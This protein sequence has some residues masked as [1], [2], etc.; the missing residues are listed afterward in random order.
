MLQSRIKNALIL[1]GNATA[2]L[3][4]ITVSALGETACPR[5][6]NLIKAMQLPYLSL[7]DEDPWHVC[8]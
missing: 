1:V 2:F 5:L 4:P 7:Y 6:Y 8:S 3:Q